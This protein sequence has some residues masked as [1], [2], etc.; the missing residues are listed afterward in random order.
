MS[1]EH[2]RAAFMQD[3]KAVHETGEAKRLYHATASDF[4]VF[5]PKKAAKNSGHPAS[6]LG[7]FLA[8]TPEAADIFS[9]VPDKFSQGTGE[10]KT[11]A[12]IMPVIAAIKNPHVMHWKDFAGAL[13]SINSMPIK[14]A[15]KAVDDF[16]QEL[17]DAGHDGILIK[18]GWKPGQFLGS[19]EFSSNNWVAF[20]R[21]QMKSD[22]GNNGDF[23]P[24]NPDITKAKGGSVS[25]S[26]VDHDSPAFRSWFGNSVLHD[27]GVPRTYYHGTSKDTDFKKFKMSRHGIWMTTDPKEASSY[28]AENDSQGFRA[29]GWSMKPTN[30]ASRVIP[31]HARIEKPFVGEMPQDFRMK[32]NYKKAQSDWFDSLRSQG[33]DGWVPKSENGNLAVAL[34][35]PGQIKSALS[36]TGDYSETG[37][38]NKADG[39]EVN[40]HKSKPDRVK[41]FVYHGTARSLVPFISK[42]GLD[43]EA[44]DGSTWFHKDPNESR[45]YAE[46]PANQFAGKKREGALLR[47]HLSK[48]PSDAMSHLSYSDITA[49]EKVVPPE[50][51]E[52]EQPDGS[53]K[54][55]SDDAEGKASKASGGSVD[56]DEDEGLTAYHGSPHDFEQFDISKIGT[57][58]GAQAYG[59]GLYFAEAEPVARGY[60][61]KLAQGTYQTSAGKVLDPYGDLEHL[62]IRVAANKSIDNAIDRA[63]GLLE[64]QPENADMIN[65]DLAKLMEAKAQGATPRTGHMYEVRIKANP[66][67][68]LDWDHDFNHDNN[69]VVGDLLPGVRHYDRVMSSFYHAPTGG[70]FYEKLS[71]IAGSHAA[72]SRLLRE[73]GVHGVQYLDAGSRD[74]G[75]GSR[76]YVVF[77]HDLVKVKR[78]Y[79]RGGAV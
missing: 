37:D 38:I 25:F 50:H 71:D 54:F 60:R 64:T 13:A 35:H 42:N 58:E 12:N 41:D 18:G 23:D 11:G 57:G 8:E 27:E 6:R 69:A 34:G 1:R 21:S 9:R 68:L 56:D 5:D 55:L 40:K 3:S 75:E 36:N 59:H 43:P 4:S 10:Y 44:S 39:G 72:A 77:D 26:P 61:D 14:K 16:R 19:P 47:V 63:R 30:T 31:V 70:E 67:Y 51:I 74:E 66:D 45:R 79:A 49:T 48:L 46:S 73:V 24:N 32:E 20:D 76:N 65:R 2:N 28:A 17:I 22:T 52:H 62:N 78:K 29:E 7:H 15:N 53:W 33:Y